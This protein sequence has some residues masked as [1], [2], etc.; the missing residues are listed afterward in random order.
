MEDLIAGSQLLM[1]FGKKTYPVTVEEIVSAADKTKSMTLLN[2][3]I[4]YYNDT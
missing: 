4:M 2:V 1:Q 3:Y